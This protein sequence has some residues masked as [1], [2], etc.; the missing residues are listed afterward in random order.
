MLPVDNYAQEYRK[1][2]LKQGGAYVNIFAKSDTGLVRKQNQD[3]YATGE[4]PG[5]VRW[6]VVCDGMGGASGGNIASSIAVA[7]TSEIIVKCYK[8]GMSSG[9]IK[10]LLSSAVEGSNIKIFDRSKQDDALTGMGTTLVAVIVAENIIHISHAGDSR[11]YMYSDKTLT[12]LTK[13]HSIVQAMVENGDIT[14][15]EAK[16]HPQKNVITRALGVEE[17]IDFD[18]IEQAIGKDDVLILCTDGLTNY[19][20]TDE[21]LEIL[22][23]SE[24]G[25]WADDL[26]A[27]AI[28]NGGGDNITV[29]AII[30][31]SS[32]EGA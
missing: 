25:D 29:V 27:C 13:D 24:T 4:L 22:D 9:S 20:A 3:A 6:A 28:K 17:S 5:N 18:Y 14:Q 12:Q 7:V 2:K 15:E 31:N 19:V 10:N 21:M 30:N 26:V 23:N 1:I 32:T 8:T 11:A 16:N